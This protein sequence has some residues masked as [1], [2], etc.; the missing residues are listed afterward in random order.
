[1]E[2][3]TYILIILGIMGFC[4]LVFRR[5]AVQTWVGNGN[6]HSKITVPASQDS[7]ESR[8][9]VPIPWG[10]P[11]NN[12]P[13]GSTEQHD[14]SD[15]LHRFVDHLISEKQTVESREYLLK[16]NE[17]LKLLVESRYGLSKIRSDGI[18]QSTKQKADS[19]GSPI[20][21]E[22]YSLEEI[23]TPWGW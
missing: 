1:M 7:P 23:K 21:F 17:N 16:R 22:R 14:V 8:L 20:I 2:Y 18:E 3:V 13:A 6:H 19:G 9:N 12:T 4:L 10:W 5:N 15:S 11:G